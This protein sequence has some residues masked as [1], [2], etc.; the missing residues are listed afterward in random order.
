MIGARLRPPGGRLPVALRLVLVLVAAS[1]SGTLDAGK[2]IPHG[3]L[4]VDERNPVIIYNDSSIDNWMGEYAF[5]LANS[6]GPPVAGLIAT[7]SGYWHNVND[8]ASGWSN[9]LTAAQSSGLKNIPEMVITST[10][11]PSLIRPT[12]GQV[13]D[14]APNNSAGASLIVNLSRE[15]SLPWRPVV[16]LAG[17]QMTDVADAYLIDHS[18]VQRVV[19]VAALG[20]Y[21]APNGVMA[22]PNGELDP[23]ADWIVAQRFQYVQV[24]AFY[25]QTMDLTTAELPD[26]PSNPLGVEMAAKQPNIFTITTAADQVSV[27]AVA[28]PAFVGAVQRAVPDTTA[29]F[30]STQGPPL[31]PA[32]NGNVWIVTQIAAPLAGATL[33]PMLLDRTIFG[34]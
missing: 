27:L 9:V 19:V 24:S 4:P 30:D 5:L 1:C 7:A 16:V 2:D 28:L 14:T 33:W 12:D 32:A 8:N 17:T 13:D 15:L 20:S 3:M 23:W 29:S 34:G 31:I 18:V 25:D 21:A 26:L 6:G 22:A 10:A 11:N